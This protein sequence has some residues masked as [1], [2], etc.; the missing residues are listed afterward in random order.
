MTND[1]YPYRCEVCG[2]A[3]WVRAAA[4]LYEPEKL[5]CQEC[6][7]EEIKKRELRKGKKN[8]TKN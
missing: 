7:I 5:L 6:H 2:R 8:G 3:A 4:T 1:E